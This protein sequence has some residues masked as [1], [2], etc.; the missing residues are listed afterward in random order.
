MAINT[1]TYIVLFGFDGLSPTNHKIG[2]LKL[3]E[4]SY[5]TVLGDCCEHQINK[6]QHRAL[7]PEENVTKVSYK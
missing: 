3:D 2:T 4:F 5:R 1:S 6:D 7:Q